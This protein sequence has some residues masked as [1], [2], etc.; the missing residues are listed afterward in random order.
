MTPRFRDG[1]M[2]GFDSTRR[3]VVVPAD[4]VAERRQLALDAL[5]VEALFEHD[6]EQ[7]ARVARRRD[8]GR[9]RASLPWPARRQLRGIAIEQ[10]QLVV[11]A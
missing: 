11:R 8:S 5:D 1:G 2:A 3:S 6:V 9:H 4:D 7:R 10:P